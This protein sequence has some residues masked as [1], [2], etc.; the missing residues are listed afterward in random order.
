V[1]NATKP[2]MIIGWFRKLVAQKFDDSKMRRTAGRPQT[3]AEVER[4]IVRMAKENTAWGYDK[5]AGT[6]AN[7]GHSDCAQ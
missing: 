1:A 4:L 6:L 5:I 2:D 7:L 3:G